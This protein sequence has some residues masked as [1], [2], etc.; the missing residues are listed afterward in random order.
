[1]NAIKSKLYIYISSLALFSVMLFLSVPQAVY[2]VGPLSIYTIPPCRIVD[3]R[4]AEPL[5][6]RLGPGEVTSFYI[7]GGLFTFQGNFTNCNIPW[8]EAQGV[9]INIVAVNPLGNTYM[10]MW[11][12]DESPPTA[13]V[14][15]YAQ[16]MPNLANGIFLPICGD[17]GC[18][19]E[20]IYVYNGP[21]GNADL[22]I[23]VTGFV[24]S[25]AAMTALESSNMSSRLSKK[26]PE[27]D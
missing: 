15:N 20:D 25:P 4:Q 10:I 24:A 17:A 6:D 16:V 12:A 22:V 14:I 1:M 13:S 7:A 11:P 21:A 5:W 3:T 9:F 19:Y 26:L 2:A 27:V 18:L 23:D 8:P